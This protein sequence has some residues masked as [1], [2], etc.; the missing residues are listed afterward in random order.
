MSTSARVIVLLSPAFM[1]DTACLEKY[2]I[3]MCCA[4]NV[5][6]AYLAP[7]YIE[8]I[9]DVPTYMGLIQYMDVR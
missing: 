8:E 6:H 5:S 4:R 3:S 2:N 9:P 7:L 1:S